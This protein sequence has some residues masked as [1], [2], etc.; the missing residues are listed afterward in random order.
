MVEL[1]ITDRQEVDLI[2]RALISHAFKC[3]NTLKLHNETKDALGEAA[4]TQVA[5][6]AKAEME[7]ALTMLA[8][9]FGTHLANSK[10]YCLDCAPTAGEE[11]GRMKEASFAWTNECSNCGKGAYYFVEPNIAV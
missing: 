1:K 10:F 7:T 4:I 9:Y 11:H 2:S 5:A 3:K 8:K 6:S